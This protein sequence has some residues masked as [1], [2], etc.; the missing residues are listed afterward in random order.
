M[1]ESP[2]T[3][4]SSNE[5]GEVKGAEQKGSERRF[6][7][8]ESQ[9]ERSSEVSQRIARK[10]WATAEKEQYPF[11]IGILVL[12]ILGIVGMYLRDA[13]WSAGIIGLVMLVALLPLVV[14]YLRTLSGRFSRQW[15]LMAGD[16][17]LFR[18]LRDSAVVL[19][20]PI[21]MGQA[22]EAFSTY[23]EVPFP[24]AI[25]A[26][27]MYIRNSALPD[28]VPPDA[29]P[30]LYVPA[31]TLKNPPGGD[32]HRVY[33]VE[34]RG[35]V[36][37]PLSIRVS[38]AESGSDV[39]IGYMLRP[40]NAQTRERMAAGLLERLQDRL[41]GAK[42]LADIRD[43]GGVPAMPIPVIESAEAFPS[44]PQPSGAL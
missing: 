13:H 27:E 44:E 11:W 32:T 14:Y 18:F 24:E 35:S 22:D 30:G 39:N 34:Y 16:G 42:I 8:L 7:A 21:E 28:P 4:N 40:S 43:S 5:S 33:E 6:V 15:A 41:I 26:I 2:D 23:L 29:P 3:V 20:H 10:H 37:R 12:A 25:R 9:L 17:E 1:T 19:G 36:S 31:A 38:A